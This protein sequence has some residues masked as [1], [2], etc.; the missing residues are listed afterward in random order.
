MS[1]PAPRVSLQEFRDSLRREDYRGYDVLIVS[2]STP[3]ESESQQALLE[4]AYGSIE[5][6]NLAVGR[7]VV[8]LSVTDPTES[9]QLLGQSYTW[10]RA[11]ERASERGLDLDALLVEGSARIAIYHNGGRG[12]RASPITQGLGNSRGAQRLVGSI[13]NARDEDLRLELL[14]AVTLQTS[15]FARSNDGRS[16]D[17][18]WTSQLIFDR[19]LEPKATAPGA[20]IQKF[21]VSVDR[22]LVEPQSLHDFGTA[23]IDST[24]CIESFFRNKVFAARDENGEFQI[25]EDKRA[26]WNREDTEL[27]FDFG[28]FRTQGT[29]HLDLVAFYARQDTWKLAE[30]GGRIPK[31][32]CRDI[33]PHFVQPFVDVL[34][35]WRS[36]DLDEAVRSAKETSRASAEIL[37]EVA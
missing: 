7:R 5:T 20:A 8:I 24:G 13:R 6:T 23:L 11:R 9:G 21:V 34:R 26:E 29:L 3:E 32:A 36:D 30:R 28:S 10:L 25:L 37:D 19:T 27:A 33:D 16:V 4:R 1:E 35:A 14:L 18:F 17:T 15:L 2:S 22:E 31:S 12:E